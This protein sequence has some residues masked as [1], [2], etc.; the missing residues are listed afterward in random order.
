MFTYGVIYDIQ[1]DKH[2]FDKLN[3]DK[4]GECG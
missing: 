4:G 1:N 3:T 2:L